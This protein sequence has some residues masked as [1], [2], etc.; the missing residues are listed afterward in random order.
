MALAST[1]A[2]RRLKTSDRMSVSSR[3]LFIV[4]R[5]GLS[6]RAVR[7]RLSTNLVDEIGLVCEETEHRW[8]ARAGR[9]QRGGRRRVLRDSQS[10]LDREPLDHALGD[11]EPLRWGERSSGGD[12]LVYLRIGHALSLAP[13]SPRL[14]VPTGAGG[15]GPGRFSE[16]PTLALR[17]RAH[18]STTCDPRRVSHPAR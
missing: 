12:E 17:T 4:E 11:T 9:S 2:S 15:I 8:C 7:I 5:T 3:V 1:F 14:T 18:S 6:R 13:R 16:G 10:V